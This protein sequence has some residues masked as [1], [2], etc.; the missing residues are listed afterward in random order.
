MTHLHCNFSER[1]TVLMSLFSGLGKGAVEPYLQLEAQ[2][3]RLS[4]CNSLSSTCPLGRPAYAKVNRSRIVPEVGIQDL[5][6]ER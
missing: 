4:E 1:E 6:V 5:A 3:E 2:A